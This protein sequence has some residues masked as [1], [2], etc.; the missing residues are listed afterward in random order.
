[1]C[2]VEAAKLLVEKLEHFKRPEFTDV[3]LD[4]LKKEIPG[5]IKHSKMAFN[6]EDVQKSKQYIQGFN[7]QCLRMHHQ[8]VYGEVGHAKNVDLVDMIPKGQETFYANCKDD[9][10]EQAWKNWLWWLPWLQ[11]EKLRFK[12][13]VACALRKIAFNQI[14]SA[15][16]EQVFLYLNFVVRACAGMALLEDT[17]EMW[18]MH[19]CNEGLDDDFGMVLYNE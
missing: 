15:S 2:D 7:N 12:H 14:S 11:S 16:V 4:N 19:Q 18:L 13:F 8:V 3:F 9:P 10:G 17:L 5:A 1:V 6:W